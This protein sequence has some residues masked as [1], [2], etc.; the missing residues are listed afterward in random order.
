MEELL[1]SYIAHLESVATNVLRNAPVAST[2]YE[3]VIAEHRLFAARIAA[4]KDLP[5]SIKDQCAVMQ[6]P[7]CPTRPKDRRAVLAMVHWLIGRIPDKFGDRDPHAYYLIKLSDYIED[8]GA[9]RQTTFFAFHEVQE[10]TG[11]SAASTGDRPEE[12]RSP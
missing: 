10:A 4:A 8:L 1:Y 6:L 2:D 3:Q 7:R 12:G 9:L 11:L 5:R